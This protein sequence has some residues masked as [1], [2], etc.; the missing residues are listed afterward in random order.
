MINFRDQDM[1]GFVGK[2][3]ITNI[4][5]NENVSGM[6]VDGV[7]G[8]SFSNSTFIDLNLLNSNFDGSDMSYANF[9]TH[10]Q[11]SPTS[12]GGGMNASL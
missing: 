1:S 2:N 12:I 6:T 3:L 8:I 4:Q 7:R 5:L 10:S 11:N 9:N